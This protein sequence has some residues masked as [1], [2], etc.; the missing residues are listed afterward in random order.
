M[1]GAITVNPS[2]GS[3]SSL[4][5]P[6]PKYF[7]A[8]KPNYRGLRL[9]GRIM[10]LLSTMEKLQNPATSEYLRMKRIFC[11]A[12][13]L[14][15][16]CATVAPPNGSL[17]LPEEFASR[18]R[19]S[20]LTFSPPP[21]F[22]PAP[23][24]STNRTQWYDFAVKSDNSKFE[25]RYAIK[26]WGSNDFPGMD[27]AVLLAIVHNISQTNFDRTDLNGVEIHPDMCHILGA[28]TGFLTRPID[29]HSDFSTDFQKCMVQWICSNGRGS[30]YIFYL[31]DDYAQVADQIFSKNVFRSVKFSKKLDVPQP[32]SGTNAASPP[33]HS[34]FPPPKP[35]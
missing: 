8:D 13:L 7:R 34:S 24:N 5:P 2:D 32:S 19:Q 27:A 11:L 1:S 14:A 23:L 33:P 10:A 17:R 29:L 6:Q 9:P 35:K 18:L 4:P 16:A 15:A 3:H 20:N 26:P 21:G 25:I 30:A 31:F 12:P 22:S 28:D